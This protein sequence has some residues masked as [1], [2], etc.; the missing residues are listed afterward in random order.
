M[1]HPLNKSIEYIQNV[2]RG[3]LTQQIDITVHNEIGTLLSSIKNM[4]DELTRT[5]SAVREGS[6]FIYNS[7]GKFLP[8][9]V[10]FQSELNNR[11]RH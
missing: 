2:S 3:D 8:G 11:L 10:I 7:S 4:Q 9:T 6:D 5:V 1:I